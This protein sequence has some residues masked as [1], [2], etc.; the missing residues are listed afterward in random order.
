MQK[1]LLEERCFTS[2]IV[3]Q[4]TSPGKSGFEMNLML[5]MDFREIG[6]GHE[7]MK[8]FCQCL[9]LASPMTYNAYQAINEK[10]LVAYENIAEDSMQT[11]CARIREKARDVNAVADATVAVD[12]TW[13]KS[14][15]S[16]LN[17]VVVA[18]SLNSK[19]VDH[20]VLTKYCKDCIA[21]EQMRGLEGYEIWKASHS[22]SI[23]HKSSAGAMEAAGA[24]ESCRRSIVKNK[25][26]YVNY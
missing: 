10:L 16:S 18:T 24:I 11:E 14:G 23:N 19:V 2:P 9:N 1:L 21:W 15:F 25:L 8:K 13:Q 26:R 3:E 17:G 7:A 20:S 12:G 4:P 5:V 6:Q 22:C